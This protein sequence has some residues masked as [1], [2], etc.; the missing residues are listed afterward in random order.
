[1]DFEHRAEQL[2]EA[3][4]MNKE[5]YHNNI[6]ILANVSVRRGCEVAA[7]LHEAVQELPGAGSALPL[8]V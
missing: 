1:M 5:A 2:V 3:I 8:A 4:K 7:D 6:V